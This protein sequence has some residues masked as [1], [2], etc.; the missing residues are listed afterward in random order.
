MI[1]KLRRKN[2]RLRRQNDRQRKLVAKRKAQGEKDRL[3]Q[4]E[5]ESALHAALV[6]DDI[7]RGVA[8]NELQPPQ[9]ASVSGPIEDRKGTL[10][11]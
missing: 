1:L 5:K 4:K 8:N 2:K 10:T 9:P 11:C 3:P 6:K 7:N